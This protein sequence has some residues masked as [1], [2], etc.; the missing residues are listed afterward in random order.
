[1]SIENEIPGYIHGEVLPV[2]QAEVDRML[3]GYV[4]EQKIYEKMHD[5]MTDREFR[6]AIQN[7][8]LKRAYGK[9]S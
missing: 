5:C 6:I 9:Y 2:H 1:M 8:K 3:S 4:S 7:G